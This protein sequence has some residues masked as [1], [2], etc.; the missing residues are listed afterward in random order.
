LALKC[1][2]SFEWKQRQGIWGLQSK[3]ARRGVQFELDV[4]CP[5][6]AAIS[7]FF[8]TLQCMGQIDRKIQV[9]RW[10]VMRK[11]IWSA[12]F[13]LSLTM[14]LAIPARAQSDT[15]RLQGTVA[16]AQGGVIAGAA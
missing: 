13:V 4:D 15:A 11:A 10:Q 8:G 16:D 12:F 7:L 2:V 6:W 5:V 14:A 1:R 9:W 3:M